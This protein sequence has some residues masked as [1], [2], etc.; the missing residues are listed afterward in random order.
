MTP[1]EGVLLCFM[2]IRAVTWNDSVGASICLH[3]TP[4]H[5]LCTL[6]EGGFVSFV[7]QLGPL[8]LCAEPTWLGVTRRRS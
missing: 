7:H 1:R 6:T 3:L 8:V 4:H 2:H 5:E